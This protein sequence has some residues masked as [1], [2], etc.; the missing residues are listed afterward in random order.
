[1]AVHTVVGLNAVAFAD[2]LMMIFIANSRLPSIHHVAGR[3]HIRTRWGTQEM[4]FV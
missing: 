1:M 4:W 2:L 3:I